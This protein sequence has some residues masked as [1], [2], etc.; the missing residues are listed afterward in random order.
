MDPVYYKSQELHMERYRSNYAMM[1]ENKDLIL[2]TYV[3]A[4]IFWILVCIFIK[5]V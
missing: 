2:Q 5:K 1:M 4:I 3:G